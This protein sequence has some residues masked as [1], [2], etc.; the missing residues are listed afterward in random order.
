M[1]EPEWLKVLR[2]ERARFLQEPGQPMVPGGNI[3]PRWV[4]KS[5]QVELLIQIIIELRL[6]RKAVEE[7]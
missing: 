4:D 1:D 6:L 7:I 2:P 3:Y 5:G